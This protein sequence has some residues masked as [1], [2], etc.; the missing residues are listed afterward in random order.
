MKDAKK[1]RRGDR[2]TSFHVE[3]FTWENVTDV[4]GQVLR[5]CTASMKSAVSSRI[6]LLTNGLF[7]RTAH[8]A[9]FI[10]CS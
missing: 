4:L 7:R 1:K 3:D 5:G 2:E 6:W 10:L 9:Q 8:H